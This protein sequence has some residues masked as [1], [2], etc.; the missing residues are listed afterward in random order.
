METKKYVFDLFL[1]VVDKTLNVSNGLINLHVLHKEY[2]GK[3][4]DGNPIYES[5][6][7]ILEVSQNSGDD[8]KNSIENLFI[9]DIR[10]FNL[11][12][13]EDML[14]PATRKFKNNTKIKLYSNLCEIMDE[15]SIKMHGKV[16]SI[17]TVEK[18]GIISII[19]ESKQK[20]DGTDSIGL[21]KFRV[22]VM[23]QNKFY[24]SYKN[25][26][27]VD[28]VIPLYF[29]YINPNSIKNNQIIDHSTVIIGDVSNI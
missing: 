10:E 1:E 27:N 3:S 20:I 6:S 5:T 22:L 25:N 2:I 26:L 11:L 15:K 24:D 14:D 16:V 13:T 8:F 19:I 7:L 9:G 21:S 28:D 18:T 17:S 29:P 23:P 4:N 12:V